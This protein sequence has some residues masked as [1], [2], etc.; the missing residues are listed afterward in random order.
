MYRDIAQAQTIADGSL[1]ADPYYR[2]EKL[3][4]N[5]LMPLVVAAVSKPLGLPVQKTY[6]RIGAYLN[7]LAPIAFYVW[8]YRLAGVA[9]A[10]AATFGFVFYRET[11]APHWVTAAYSPWLFAMTSSQSLMYGSLVAYRAALRCGGVSRYVVA[12]L[13]TGLTF[14]AAAPPALML[15][16]VLTAG[17]LGSVGRAQRKGSRAV[18]R[19]FTDHLVLAATAL[20]VASP[21]LYFILWH[22]KLRVLNSAP[23]LWHWADLETVL[24]GHDLLWP[25]LLAIAGAVAL[26]LRRIVGVGPPLARLA[27]LCG[28]ASPAASAERNE[29]DGAHLRPRS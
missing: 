2:G 19:A 28:P 23:T 25:R 3:W 22:Y 29:H 11:W 18:Q 17:V 15:A 1:F 20:A 14:L 8:V 7:L 9:G 5:P 12:G 21:F 4:H 16:G 26:A 24:P 27:G 13:L 6:V 10:A